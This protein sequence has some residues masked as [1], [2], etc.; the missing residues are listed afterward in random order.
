MSRYRIAHPATHLEIIVGWDPPLQTYFAQVFD[1]RDPNAEDED[2]CILWVGTNPRVPITSV[3]A[4]QNCLTLY[5]TIPESI[6]TA[7][8]QDRQQSAPPTPLQRA[9]IGLV[10]RREGP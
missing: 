9:M 5:A 3:N 1:W 8:Q 10:T 6:R 2:A 4:L 7:L